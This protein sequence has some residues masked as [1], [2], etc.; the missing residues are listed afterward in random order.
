VNPS[1][2]RSLGPGSIPARSQIPSTRYPRGM[3]ARSGVAFQRVA[4]RTDRA[5]YVRLRRFP[6]ARSRIVEGPRRSFP[7]STIKHWTTARR[8]RRGLAA[9]ALCRKP[10]R[11]SGVRRRSTASRKHV[12]DAGVLEEHRDR[13]PRRGNTIASSHLPPLR[14]RL[15]ATCWKRRRLLARRTARR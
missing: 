10:A 13:C 6:S 9:R 3:A 8:S 1:L 12:D 7:D 2:V 5:R 15:L 11:W 14:H 4:S